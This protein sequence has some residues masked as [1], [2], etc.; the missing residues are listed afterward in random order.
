MPEQ[1]HPA[2]SSQVK[3]LPLVKKIVSNTA[4]CC[5]IRCQFNLPAQTTLIGKLIEF[6]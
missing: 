2:W 5:A 4:S 3:T 6:P 1:E